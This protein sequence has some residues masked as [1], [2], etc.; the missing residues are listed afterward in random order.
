LRDWASICLREKA[1]RRSFDKTSLTTWSRLDIDILY[2]IYI[3]CGDNLG[4]ATKPT[5]FS[6]CEGSE[7]QFQSGNL[8]ASPDLIPLQGIGGKNSPQKGK[9]GG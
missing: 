8:E 3:L 7:Y 1:L 5:L 4:L 6:A 2:L 9:L